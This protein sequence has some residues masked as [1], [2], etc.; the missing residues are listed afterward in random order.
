MCA[1]EREVG[2]ALPTAAARR[3]APGEPKGEGQPGRERMSQWR[4]G[5]PGVR[6]CGSCLRLLQGTAGKGADNR[7]CGFI[8]PYGYSYT[9][10]ADTITTASSY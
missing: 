4:G 7:P 9:A 6:A 8:L 2:A 10:A 3:G 5:R 1:R